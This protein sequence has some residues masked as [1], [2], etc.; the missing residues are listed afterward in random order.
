MKRSAHT[1]LYE[2]GQ[3]K[4]ARV[5]IDPFDSVLAY[6]CA[7]SSITRT[8]SPEKPD[9][10]QQQQEEAEPEIQPFARIYYYPAEDYD[11]TLQMQPFGAFAFVESQ[12]KLV[13]QCFQP[14]YTGQ[15]TLPALGRG[16]YGVVFNFQ[17]EWPLDEIRAVLKIEKVI[18]FRNFSHLFNRLSEFDKYLD[19]G[20]SLRQSYLDPS[21]PEIEDTTPAVALTTTGR[22]KQ[23][24]LEHNLKDLGLGTLLD[25][26]ARIPADKFLDGTDRYI[27]MCGYL[28]R[29][30]DTNV[31][32]YKS[33]F[34]KKFADKSHLLDYTTFAQDF[35]FDIA[36]GLT[37]LHN[38]GY[39]HSDIKP[40][41][42]CFS[43]DTKG[44]YLVDFGLAD[45]VATTP[46]MTDEERLEGHLICHEYQF[47][48]IR[49][50]FYEIATPA[51]EL[52]TLLYTL[53]YDFTEFPWSN[54]SNNNQPDSQM[55]PRVLYDAVVKTVYR[56]E[57]LKTKMLDN[58]VSV[59]E[60]LQRIAA[61]IHRQFASSAAVNKDD[62]EFIHKIKKYTVWMRRVLVHLWNHQAKHFNAPLDIDA[63][64]QYLPRY[65]DR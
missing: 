50:I 33:T 41:N 4:T 47:A 49:Q 64:L 22:M 51:S 9:T 13:E 10:Q 42:I 30:F 19:F 38:Q 45:K 21:T 7:E 57:D 11:D 2:S 40:A 8:P 12:R 63:L 25:F 35:F 27:P 5:D 18:Q 31:H 37:Y 3:E 34:V 44:Y 14:D 23:Y 36:H 55:V 56:E 43:Y 60:M 58:E 53:F 48:S 1:P 26:R 28:L 62:E 16:T 65:A 15:I 24:M 54:K 59:D 61:H 32:K 39:V 6:W 46:R 17:L 29:G 52:E 20:L